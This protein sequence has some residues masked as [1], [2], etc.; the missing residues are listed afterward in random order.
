MNTPEEQYFLDNLKKVLLIAATEAANKFV[1]ES[2]MG[3]ATVIK[4]IVPA[5]GGDRMISIIITV[6]PNVKNYVCNMSNSQL[7]ITEDKCSI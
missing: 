5:N 4:D 2:L 1:G 3:P 6:D 7:K